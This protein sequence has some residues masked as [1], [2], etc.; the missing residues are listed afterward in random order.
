MP[1]SIVATKEMVEDIFDGAAGLYDS[2]G[3]DIFTRFGARLV[4]RMAILPGAHV[5]DV[6]TGKGAVLIPA[7]QRIGPA[8]RVIGIDVSSAMLAEARRAARAAGLANIETCRMDAER[9]D[10][11]DATFDVVTCAFSLFF[12]PAMDAALREMRRVLKPGGRIGIS[13]WG[14]EPFGIGW[15]ILAKQF[16]AYE[17]VIR[18]PQ[19]VVF[20]P[21]DVQ[22]LLG[23][24]GFAG[25]EAWSE[26]TEV[27]YASAEEWWSFQLTLGS[28]AAIYWLDEEMRS[29]FK[30]EYLE[31]MRPYFQA[32][33]LHLPAPVV[34]A[35]AS[36]GPIPG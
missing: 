27:V 28:R 26:T 10:F 6:G 29:K 4:E 15:K 21:E 1:K 13:L 7:A 17:A 19:R 35:I 18:M 22:T 11:A 2:T 23:A 24:A 12:F 5:L 31:K 30:T 14:R 8:G 32:D 3:P 34:Y 33:G 25:I 36:A 9:L 20:L 16:S